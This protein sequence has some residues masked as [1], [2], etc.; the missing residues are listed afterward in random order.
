MSHQKGFAAERGAPSR[1][2]R[3]LGALSARSTPGRFGRA[4]PVGSANKAS[5]QLIKR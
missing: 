4:L 3:Q 1:G 2:S 5:V